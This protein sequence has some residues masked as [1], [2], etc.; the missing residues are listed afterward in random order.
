MQQLIPVI[1]VNG[2]LTGE[3][4]AWMPTAEQ[5]RLFGN[6]VPSFIMPAPG[7]KGTGALLVPDTRGTTRFSTGPLAGQGFLAYVSREGDA[8]WD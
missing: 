7:M 4:A 2:S 6:R 5:T 8:F 1:D 3:W